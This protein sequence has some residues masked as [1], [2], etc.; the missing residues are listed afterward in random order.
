M[1]AREPVPEQLELIS[2]ELL[3]PLHGIFHHLVQQV[4]NFPCYIWTLLEDFLMST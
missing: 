1:V 4:C 2:K 3:T